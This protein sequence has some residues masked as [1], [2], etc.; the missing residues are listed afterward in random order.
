MQLRYDG[1]SD[2]MVEAFVD[3][4]LASDTDDRKSTTGYIIY[5][6]GDPVYWRTKKQSLVVTGS[7]DAEIIAVSDALG[8]INYAA[9]ILAEIFQIERPTVVVHED[10][11]TTIKIA[12]TPLQKRSRA[13]DTRIK[14]VQQSQTLGEIQ[15]VKIAGA[16]QRADLFTKALS[17]PKFQYFRDLIFKTM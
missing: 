11:T 14:Y 8:D 4:S 10:N 9:N 16:E 6:Y 3:A 5:V 13:A 15:M 12:Q 2:V 1:Q 17:A 7:A